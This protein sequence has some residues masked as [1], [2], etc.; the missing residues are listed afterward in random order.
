MECNICV[1][2]IMDHKITILP[3]SNYQIQCAKM[4]ACGRCSSSAAVH[5]VTQWRRTEAPPHA[6][7]SKLKITYHYIL[8]SLHSL[9]FSTHK[10]YQQRLRH[11]EVERFFFFPLSE[12][13]RGSERV[14]GAP[15]VQLGVVTGCSPGAHGSW[16]EWQWGEEEPYQMNTW[17]REGTGFKAFFV[18]G[19]FKGDSCRLHKAGLYSCGG[20]PQTETTPTYTHTLQRDPELLPADSHCYYQHFFIQVIRSA[21]LLA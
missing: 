11:I 21:Y 9:T 3:H 2:Q 12:T 15:E 19:F 1:Q 13:F 10:L 16:M 5:C 7:I 20:G 17:K 14:R 4:A 6:D 18:F 8:L